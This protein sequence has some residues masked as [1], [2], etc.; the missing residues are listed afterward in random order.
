MA[1]KAQ[2]DGRQHA[3]DGDHSQELNQRETATNPGA[4]GGVTAS[5]CHAA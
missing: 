1:A 5:N 3:D 4:G 2:H